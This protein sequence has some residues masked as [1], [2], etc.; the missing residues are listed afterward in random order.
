MK[1]TLL[2]LPILVFAWALL[3]FSDLAGAAV[4]DGLAL[5][6][7]AIIP[8]LLPFFVVVSLLLQLGFARRLQPLFAPFMGPLFHLSGV[9]AAP[10]LAGLVGGYPTGAKTVADL[11]AAGQINRDEAERAL[12]FV[13]NCG[14]AFLLSYVGASVLDSSQAGVYLLLIHVAAA[15]LTGLIL[16]RRTGPRRR[17]AAGRLQRPANDASLAEAF[18][19]AVTGALASTLNICGF[20]VLFRVIA[21]LLLGTLPAGVLGFFEMVTGTAALSPGRLGFLTAAGI[22]GWGG[23]SV[24][25]QTMAVLSGTGLSL[26][27]HWLGKALQALLSV[28][29]A[30]AVSLWLYP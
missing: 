28:L 19:S 27:R 10:L 22:V 6:F 2:F 3:R 11:Y 8:S 5:C 13:N 18:P 4:Q 9:C 30:G 26:R 20:V 23:L 21:A 25:C 12:S 7:R 14:P 15:L 1:K 16:C 17:A 29:L 24:H